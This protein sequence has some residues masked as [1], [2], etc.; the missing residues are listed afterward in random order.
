MEFEP[1]ASFSTLFFQRE[2]VPF[3]QELICTPLIYKKEKIFVPPYNI[4]DFKGFSCEVNEVQM[5]I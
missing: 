4:I 5:I 3:E 2:E 1:M